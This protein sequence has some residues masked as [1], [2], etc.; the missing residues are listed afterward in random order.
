MATTETT[1]TEKVPW[2][3]AGNNAPVFDEVTLTDLE[4]KGAIPPELSGRYFRNGA[5]PQTGSSPHWF[6]GDGMI[7][8]IELRDGTAT[9]YRNRYVKTPCLERP[10]L[11]RIEM[12]LDPETLQLD[13]RMSVANT[14][15]ISHAGRIMALEEGAF[16]YVLDAELE[17]VGPWDFGGLLNTAMT[18]HPKICPSTGELLLFGYGT[19]APPYLTYHRV[20]AN[21]N[22]VQS[23]E[24]T[25]NGPTMIHDFS[26][27]RNHTVFMDLPA[28][29]DMEAAMSGGMPIRW[30]DD[31]PSRFGI[32]PREGTDA[33]V[34]WFDVDPCYVFHTL[35]AHDD[36]DTVVVRGCRLPELWRDTSAMEMGDAPDPSAGPRLHEWR[37]DLATGKV[38]EGPLDDQPVDFPRV[39]DRDVGVDARY[40]YCADFG[41]EVGRTV[42]Y[43]LADGSKA[44]H[45]F[46]EGHSPGEPVFIASADATSPDDGW[47]TTYVYDA[48]TDTSYM[49]LLDASDFTGPPVAEV[50]LP[51][52]IPTGFHGS[53]IPDA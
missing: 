41:G 47:V 31:Y 3:L 39:A 8:G 15:V 5:N 48:G 14:H 7:H 13:F 34:Q 29:F 11:T 2:H 40:G 28:V 42:K 20:D 46:P 25:V 43:D 21:G 9:W 23:S 27:S 53:W 6:V 24:I 30:D 44:L 45:E 1:Q 50:H 26:V 10:D 4:V 36:G 38:S 32:M 35:N 19:I 22:L 37:F 33:D 18:A 17:T 52:R 51:R 12:M 49:V 16:P